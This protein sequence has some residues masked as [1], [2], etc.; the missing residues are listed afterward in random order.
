[1]IFA[2]YKGG[3]GSGHFTKKKTY[4]V[5]QRNIEAVNLTEV[6]VQDDEGETVKF[7][8][9]TDHRFEFCESV[10]AVLRKQVGDLK[11][12]T[13]FLVDDTDISLRGTYFQCRDRDRK[14]RMLRAELLLPLDHH[15][16]VPGI[17]LRNTQTGLWARTERVDGSMWVQVE[18]SA[19]FLPLDAYGLS[20]SDGEIDRIRMACCKNA[21]GI[22]ALTEGNQYRVLCE[23]SEVI[24]VES[25]DGCVYGYDPERFE[26]L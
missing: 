17:E 1:M 19:E 15:N 24:E 20:V 18:G 25:D 8:P 9:E 6:R 23:S 3:G 26:F 13:V 2:R 12:G 10:F 4:L 5:Q 7:N 14:S 11:A 16:I 21:E 22:Q